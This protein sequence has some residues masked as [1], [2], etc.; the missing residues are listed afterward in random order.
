[1]SFFDERPSVLRDIQQYERYMSYLVLSTY[2]KH[3]TPDKYQ[4]KLYATYTSSAVCVKTL[5]GIEELSG[6]VLAF[7]K[8]YPQIEC[9]CQ[10]NFPL[11]TKLREMGCILSD[12]AKKRYTRILAN[13]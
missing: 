4:A 7:Q 5:Y 11:L 10:T 12:S 13:K 9:W 3:N 2:T 6:F 1:M 8:L